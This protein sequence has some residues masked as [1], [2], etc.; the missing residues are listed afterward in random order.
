MNGDDKPLVRSYLSLQRAVGVLGVLLPVILVI[1]NW[2]LT[3]SKVLEKSISHYFHT[4]M[5]GVF[6]GVLFAIGVFLFFYEGYKPD[7]AE[8]AYQPSDNVAGNLACVF[9]LGVALFPTANANGVS[10]WV[11]RVHAL[12]AAGMFLTLAYFSLFLFTKTNNPKPKKPKRTRNRWYR[13]FGVIILACIAL[14]T[15]Y[16]TLPDD[17]SIAVI[18]PVFW[19]ESLALWAFGAA[20]FIKGE[21]LWK[22][23]PDG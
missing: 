4:D 11:S 17:N 8:K 5:G 15:I 21:T 16:N 20:W 23:D 6:V 14:I 10:D 12:S 18:K 9:A 19:L 13:T 22:D 2:V 7:P 1:G 3:D